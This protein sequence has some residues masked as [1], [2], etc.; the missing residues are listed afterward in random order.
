M[1]GTDQIAYPSQNKGRAYEVPELTSAVQIGAV[2]DDV[3][4]D[5]SLVG[6]QRSD[7]CC[8]QGITSLE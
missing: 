6:M 4:V 7:P 1:L 5:V 8:C 2:K 3:I